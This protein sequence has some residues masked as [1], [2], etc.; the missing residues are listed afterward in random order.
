MTDKLS[1]REYAELKQ[2]EASASIGALTPEERIKKWKHEAAECLEAKRD[3]AEARKERDKFKA[4][5]SE[6]EGKLSVSSGLRR[7]AEA[8]VAELEG[9]LETAALG[10]A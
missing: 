5:I 9:N 4:R 8:R 6:L 1:D 3:A 10:S 7:A 2:R